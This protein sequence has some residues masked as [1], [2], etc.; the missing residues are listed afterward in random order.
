MELGWRLQA[1][2]GGWGGGG[3]SDYRRALIQYSAL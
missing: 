3:K 1:G 2:F